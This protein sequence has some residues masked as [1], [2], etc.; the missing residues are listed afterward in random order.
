M[1]S[2]YLLE[3]REENWC[4]PEL[5]RWECVRACM[6]RCHGVGICER[7]RGYRVNVLV[8]AWCASKKG[9]KR[10]REGVCLWAWESLRVAN[11]CV[12]ASVRVCVWQGERMWKWE[13]PRASW[14][15]FVSILC[16]LSFSADCSQRPQLLLGR[17]FFLSP[18]ELSYYRRTRPTKKQNLPQTPRNTFL[19]LQRPNSQLVIKLSDQKTAT[20]DWMASKL[21]L[22]KPWLYLSICFWW[23]AWN[24]NILLAEKFVSFFFHEFL[25]RRLFVLEW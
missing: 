2:I 25:I 21:D 19:Y 18:T 7:M 4:A 22:K 20:F 3:E 12:R 16:E 15:G 9:R 13:V 11:K 5:G 8:R 10:K 1:I 17:T 6:D 23:N 24:K 14:N